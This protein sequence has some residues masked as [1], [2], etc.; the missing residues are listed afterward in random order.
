[1][2]GAGWRIPTRWTVPDMQ[3]YVV[4]AL[5]A[6]GADRLVVGSD[7]SVCLEER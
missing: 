3:S 1:M 4:V 2:T 5:D 7:W 6:L